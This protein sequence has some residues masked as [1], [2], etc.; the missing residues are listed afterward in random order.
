[1]TGKHRVHLKG[2]SSGYQLF[3]MT[4]IQER[5]CYAG[6]DSDLVLETVHLPS[7]TF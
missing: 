5:I 4:I 6:F 1:M 7:E 2:G 3:G